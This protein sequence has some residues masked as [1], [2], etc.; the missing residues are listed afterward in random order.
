MIDGV[1]GTKITG[2]SELLQLYDAMKLK[3]LISIGHVGFWIAD[4]SNLFSNAPAFFIILR[5]LKN[6]FLDFRSLDVL[7][8][9]GEAIGIASTIE[10]Y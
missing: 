7:V 6:C 8:T 3:S 4:S 5:C 2:S 10:G 9:G 1:P